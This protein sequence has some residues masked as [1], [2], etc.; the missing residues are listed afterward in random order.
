MEAEMKQRSAP[1]NRRGDLLEAAARCFSRSGYAATA[2]RDIALETGIRA[3]SIYYHFPSKDELFFAVYEAGV[4]EITAA[5]RERLEGRRDPW[6]R[7]E[8]AC[9]AHLEVLLRGACLRG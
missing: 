6:E 9:A 8:A 4:E 5:V 3:G 2:M 7:L 1:L